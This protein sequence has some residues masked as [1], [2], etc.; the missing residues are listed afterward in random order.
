M[1]NMNGHFVIGIKPSGLV[2][3][4]VWPNFCC[5]WCWWWCWWW[6]VLR[7]NEAVTMKCSLS[8]VGIWRSDLYLGWAIQ[9]ALNMR[10]NWIAAMTD[11]GKNIF[12][13]N[14]SEPPFHQRIMILDLVD[15]SNE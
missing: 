5:S 13:Y 7:K 4:G 9:M 12:D 3:D 6:F 14:R 8:R 10:C 15:F 11:L 1:E 2:P